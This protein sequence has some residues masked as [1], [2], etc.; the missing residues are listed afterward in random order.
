LHQREHVQVDFHQSPLGFS[1]FR[2]D[3]LDFLAD[4]IGIAFPVGCLDLLVKFLPQP[5]DVLGVEQLFLNRADDVTE[6]LI[7]GNR[8]PT[9]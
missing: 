9:A 5:V 2:F 6:H 8:V 3:R 4:R 1:K 7:L